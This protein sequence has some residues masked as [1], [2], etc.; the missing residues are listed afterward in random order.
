MRLRKRKR[1]ETDSSSDEYIPS[2]EEEVYSSDEE[3][4]KIDIKVKGNSKAMANLNITRKEIQREEPKIV[5]IL[6]R[7]MRLEDRAKILTMYNI[8]KRQM[9]YTDEWNEHRKN[10]NKKL[11]EY[12]QNW[13]HHKKYTNHQHR[14]MEK[15]IKIFSSVATESELSLKYKILQLVASDHTKSI[16][17]KKYTRFISMKASDD[18][19]GKMKNWLTWATSIPHDRKIV[20]QNAASNII[21]EISNKLN[22]ELYGMKSVKEQIL[23]FI[24]A[25]LMNPNMKRCNLGLVG[26]P[27]V[28]KTKISRLLASVLK[29]PFEQISFGGVSGTEFL[30]GHDYTYI[31]SGPGE[32]VRALARMKYK[33]GILFFDEYEKVSGNKNIASSLLHITDP[34]QNSEFRDNFLAD[35]NI[36]LSHLWFIYS[37]NSLPHDSALKDRIYVINVPGYSQADKIKMTQQ[38]LLPRACENSGIPKNSITISD[39][40]SAYLIQRI[41]DINEK[42]VRTLE[43]GIADIVNKINFI[44]LNQ[45]KNGNINID[46]SFHLKNKLLSYPVK[47]NSKMVKKF[48]KSASNAN[49]SFSHM[50]C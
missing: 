16:I 39:S 12:D 22:S 25:K 19:Y 8:Y 43:K 44:I 6:T 14:M 7:P 21:Q 9:V 29:W 23:L 11:Q 35:I 24:N 17:Y 46:V 5:D 47:I 10:I 31:G 50:Y 13:I 3:E 37:M 18:E 1:V 2:S 15:K 48:T 4:T 26:S 41:C 40:A 20:V 27:G 33:N 36:D 49:S 34:S 45:D 32:I 38:F 30:K 42:G 28:G